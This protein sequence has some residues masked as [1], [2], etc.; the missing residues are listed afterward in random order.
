MNKIELSTNYGYKIKSE[1]LHILRQELHK[2]ICGCIECIFNNSYRDIIVYIYYDR[3]T[4]KIII[5]LKD[6]ICIDTPDI[7]IMIEYVCKK[8]HEMIMNERFKA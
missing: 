8:Y 2:K 3:F 6:F 4:Y 5:P 7:K 1:I